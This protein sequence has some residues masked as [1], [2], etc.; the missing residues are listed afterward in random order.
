MKTFPEILKEKR[1][2]Y[3]DTEAA[4]EFAAEEYAKEQLYDFYRWI[5]NNN[6]F[7]YWNDIKHFV[8]EY[9]ETKERLL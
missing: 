6:S 2:Y 4:I 9:L 7:E 1:D 5:D 3:G 8:D